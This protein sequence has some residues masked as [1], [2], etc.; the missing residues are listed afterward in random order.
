MAT[1]M[2]VL[3]VL[4]ATAPVWAVAALMIP[5]GLGGPLIMPPLAAYLLDH[6]PAHRAGVASGILNTARQIGGALAVAV[7]GALLADHAGFLRGL[8]TSL[9][10]T[11]VVLLAATAATPLL[12]GPFT[13]RRTRAR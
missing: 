4:P 13:A 2:T 1:G 9:I 11:V 5:V 6:V 8:R 3:A 10:I 7:F 12:T